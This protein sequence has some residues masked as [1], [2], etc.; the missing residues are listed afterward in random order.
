MEECVTNMKAEMGKSLINQNKKID[1]LDRIM[2]KMVQ[3]QMYLQSM[4]STHQQPAPQQP[5]PYPP[6]PDTRCLSC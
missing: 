3:Q 6:T 2:N 1:Q 5:V 4:Q